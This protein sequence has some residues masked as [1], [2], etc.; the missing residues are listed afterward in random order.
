MLKSRKQERIMLQRSPD[1][2]AL[3][4]TTQIGSVDVKGSS[5]RKKLAQLTNREDRASERALDF[6]RDIGK[7]EVDADRLAWA[8][9]QKGFPGSRVT[10]AQSSDWNERPGLF[11]G[12]VNG[13]KGECQVAVEGLT[14]SQVD[15]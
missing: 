8:D 6:Y 2:E 12:A 13:V 10:T 7:S 5:I 4:A 3:T 1:L 15:K 14:D 9:I 11:T